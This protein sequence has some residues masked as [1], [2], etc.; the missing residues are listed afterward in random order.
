MEYVGDNAQRPSHHS[1]RHATSVGS[2]SP[3]NSHDDSYYRDTSHQHAPG[4]PYHTLKLDDIPDWLGS[5]EVI[6]SA[7]TVIFQSAF[8]SLR[9]WPSR[10]LTLCMI[11]GPKVSLTFASYQTIGRVCHLP[12]TATSAFHDHT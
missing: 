12:Q 6:R 8:T 3:H 9:L 1:P 10:L 5:Q 2:S 4:R 11:W 7:S